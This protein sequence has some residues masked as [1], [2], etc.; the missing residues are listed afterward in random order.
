MGTKQLLGIFGSIALF[1]G[2]FM[3]IVSIPI[4]GSMNYFQNGRGDG[5]IVL[6]FGA[7]SLILALAKQFRGLWLT[8]L[9][10]LG[11]MLFTFINFQSKISQAKTEMESQL[12]GN[13]FRGLAE[14]AMQSVQLQWGWAVLIVGAV[15]IIVAAAIKDDPK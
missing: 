1:I 10:S 11:I 7:I 5:T 13:P 15:L 6:I 2:V 9:G 3:P 14:I 12:A 4:M 8:G